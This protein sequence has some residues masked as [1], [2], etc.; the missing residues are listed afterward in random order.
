[1]SPFSPLP[2]ML[3]VPSTGTFFFPRREMKHAQAPGKNAITRHTVLVQATQG[4][5]RAKKRYPVGYFTSHGYLSLLEL[6]VF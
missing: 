3:E 2:S 6:Q 5:G 4:K 1:V